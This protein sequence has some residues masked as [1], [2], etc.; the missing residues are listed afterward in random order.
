[1]III[2][3]MEKISQNNTVRFIKKKICKTLIISV[4]H[5]KGSFNFVIKNTKEKNQAFVSNCFA[6]YI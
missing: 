1:M 3:E 5:E 2:I 4:E 6:D